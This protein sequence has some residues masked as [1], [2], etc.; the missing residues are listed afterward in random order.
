M[1]VCISI[2][3]GI[4]AG[5]IINNRLYT[6]KQ[7]EAGEIGHT[8]V[9]DQNFLERKAPTTIESICSEDAIIDTIRRETG[10]QSLQREDVVRR[11]QQKDPLIAKILDDFCFY[12]ADII[13]NTVVTF[14]PKRVAL[15]SGLIAALP[16]LLTKIKAYIPHLTNNETQIYLVDD[17]RNCT[18]LGACSTIIHYLLEVET[19]QLNFKTSQKTESEA[20]S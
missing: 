17:V 16:E 14:D 20:Q 1:I 6:G 9:Y 2:H 4:G 13:Y 5:I 3:K 19:G 12:T 8:I 15:N 7:G 10:D 18:L 11:Y